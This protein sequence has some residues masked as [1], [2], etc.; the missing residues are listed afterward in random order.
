MGVSAVSIAYPHHHRGNR[1]VGFPCSGASAI[2]GGASRGTAACGYA[3]R[4]RRPG[5]RASARIGPW[6]C[7]RSLGLPQEDEVRNVVNAVAKPDD[8]RYPGRQTVC[9]VR[10]IVLLDAIGCV[11]ADKIA[12]ELAGGVHHDEAAGSG[13]DDQITGLCDGADQP[14]DQ[15][16]GFDVRVKL[17]VDLLGPTVGD[18]MVPPCRTGSNGRLLEHEHIIAALSQAIPHA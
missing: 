3:H 13:V 12:P 5:L 11:A 16:N 15:S 17:A 14:L 8:G 4:R 6:V 9:A 2:A 7:A 10:T 18:A 1:S